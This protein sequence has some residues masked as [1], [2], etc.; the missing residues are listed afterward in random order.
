VRLALRAAVAAAPIAAWLAAPATASAYCR[1]AACDQGVG[2]RCAPEGPTDCGT[3]LTWPRPCI[4]YAL[5][6]DGTRLT[7][8][9]R[10]RELV[11]L[12]FDQWEGADCGGGATPKLSVVEIGPVACGEQGFD[13]EGPNANVI[14]FRDD[15]WPYSA[16]AL[17]LTTVTYG[18]DTGV[19]RDADMEI[20][21]SDV[22]F[23]FDDASPA[24]DFLSIVTHEAGHF[25]GLAHSSVEGA[26]MVL[27]YERGT[28]DL[29][30][31]AEDDLAGI[32]A[33]YGTG[34]V[35]ACDP[36][37]EGGL[38]DT[39]VDPVIPEDDGGGGGCCAV[40][41]GARARGGGPGV[42]A[43][44][45]GVVAALARRRARGARAS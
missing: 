30:T 21:T 31:L 29:R 11:R 3:V 20:N 7:S 24:Y 18:L 22:E 14:V 19:I 40:A 34:E 23:T 25:L 1:T 6:E 36:V 17:A 15:D 10:A 32:C 16:R 28:T 13:T 38:E 33:V 42:I 37:P 4:S 5:Q 8:F 9:E 43:A 35:G 39:C 27:S 41:A 12:G 26:T 44:A 2:A 45:V